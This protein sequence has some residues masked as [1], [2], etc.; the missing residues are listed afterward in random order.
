MAEADTSL[1]E[2]KTAAKKKE[3]LDR[4]GFICS[5]TRYP[6]A[7]PSSKKMFLES[8]RS[9]KWRKMLD[10]WDITCTKDRDHL[11]SRLR[12]GVPDCVRGEVWSRLSGVLSMWAHTCNLNPRLSLLRRL[13]T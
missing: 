13:M 3:K 10:K 12:K 4:Y 6:C 1:G 7:L 5:K 2:T 9:Q 8:S 11:K